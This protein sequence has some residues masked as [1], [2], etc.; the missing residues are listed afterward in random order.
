MDFSQEPRTYLS[1]SVSP[2]TNLVG[3]PRAP[4]EQL[5]MC[6]EQN[7]ITPRAVVIR[8]VGLQFFWKLCFFFLSTHPLSLCDKAA[9]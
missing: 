2:P 9:D 6:S 4:R 7:Y 3:L 1:T 5:L 8:N